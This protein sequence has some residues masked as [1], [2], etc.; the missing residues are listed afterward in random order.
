VE[1]QGVE[2]LGD[3]IVIALQAPTRAVQG[4]LDFGSGPVFHVARLRE[5]KVARVRVYLDHQQA[6][7]AARTASS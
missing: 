5:G 1:I 3:E 2:V 4:D 7:E 6:V